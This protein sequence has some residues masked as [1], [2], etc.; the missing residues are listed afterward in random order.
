[1][2]PVRKLCDIIESSMF[3]GLEGQACLAHPRSSKKADRPSQEE[4]NGA[5]SWR[6]SWALEG[7]DFEGFGA[8][9]R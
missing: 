9:V 6:A 8:N 5:G 1:M 4:S 3:K 2:G 7:F